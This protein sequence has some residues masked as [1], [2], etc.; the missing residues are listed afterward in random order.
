[1][2]VSA[3][4]LV[5]GST[6]GVTPSST[7]TSAKELIRE[8]LSQYGL[9]DLA[10]WAWNQYLSSGA[11]DVST[12]MA[13]IG[14]ELR[15]QPSYKARFPA[16]DAL[17]KQGH[18][19]SESDYV[20]YEKT[21]SQVMRAAGLPAGF[22]D[23]PDDF[24]KFLSNNISPTEIQDRV[25]MAQ[26]AIYTAGPETQAQLQALYGAGATPGQV[27][28]FFLDPDK[29]EPL[30]AKQ[31][32]AAQASGQGVRS[33]YGELSR[34]EAEGVAGAGLT[35]QGLQEGFTGLVQNAQLFDQQIGAH[36]DTVAPVVTRDEQLGAAFKGDAAAQQRIANEAARRRATFTQGGQFAEAEGKARG[37]VGAGEQQSV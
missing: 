10:D 12:A 32:A 36:A 14:P 27:T 8:A 31:W 15:K 25:Q 7:D 34:D 1:M 9:G 30:I 23:K 37:F 4:P 35:A 21:V 17:S 29:A 22:Y 6:G 28:A 26:V 20:N 16:M 2:A 19:I 5:P 3:F 18:A 13:I 33:G 11:T 24:A